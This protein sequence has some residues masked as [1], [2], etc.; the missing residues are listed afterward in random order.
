MAY[1]FTTDSQLL[2]H[3]IQLFLRHLLSFSP[4]Q[5]RLIVEHHLSRASLVQ[6]SSRL[7]EN[8]IAALIVS[9]GSYGILFDLREIEHD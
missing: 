9:I 5:R 3:V 2:K 1:C 4:S 7:I 6:I 8:I